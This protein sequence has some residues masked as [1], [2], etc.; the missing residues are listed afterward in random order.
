M[1]QDNYYESG[2]RR[3][4]R[5]SS[6]RQG[7]GEYRSAPQEGHSRRP[8][9][10]RRSA[11]RTAALVL[12]YV[13]AV[14]G[15]SILLACVGW[16]AA[17]DVLALNKEA[18]E[19]IFTVSPDEKFD[20]IVDRL[21]DEG[22]VEYKLLFNIFASIT[23]G[24]DKVTAGTYT[25]NTDMDYRA[26]LSSMRANSSNRAEVRV[27]IPEGYNFDQICKL[28]EEKGVVSSA[29]ELREAAANH[30]YAFSFL[31]DIPLGDY[32]RL[33]GFL[34]PSTY[35]FYMPHNAVYA[36]NKLLVHFANQMSDELMAQV[37]AS[38]Y[39]LREILTIASLIERETTGEDRAEISAVI[40]N[41]L[42]NPDA[43]T[44]GYLQ[45]DATLVYLNGGKEPTAA[46]R[47]IDSPYNTYK[48]KGL[49]PGPIANPGMES[50]LAALNPASSKDYYYALGD[51]NVHHFF[52]TYDQLQS[53]L[54][55][56][57]RY[58]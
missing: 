7:H 55:S 29:E 51:D 26:L 20:S 35:D 28:L 5:R 16:V 36:L 22:L 10:K 25:L 44:Q 21:K 8:R 40:H 48:Y 38:G 56:Q 47:E 9:K 19:V 30:D 34:M 37:E 23:K 11:G 31:Q 17:G 24:R 4:E 12:L 46:D 2:Q 33:E 14:I 45:I 18:K 57:E 49:P 32:R 50:I 54:A 15:V 58:N 3:G 52:R 41:R 1:S 42:N 27:S 6:S 13:T 39:S 53:F 43:G